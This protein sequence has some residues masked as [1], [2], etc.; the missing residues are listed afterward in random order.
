LPISVRPQVCQP[1]AEEWIKYSVGAFRRLFPGSV[2]FAGPGCEFDVGGESPDR[3][4]RGLA[5]LDRLLAHPD[6]CGRTLVE[7]DGTHVERIVDD[8]GDGG[9]LLSVLH[10][11]RA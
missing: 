10:A 11:D 4:C 8:L 2:G 6:E 3:A 5:V 9:V 7:K 1:S